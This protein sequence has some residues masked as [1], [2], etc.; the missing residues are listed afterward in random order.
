[1]TTP[2]PNSEVILRIMGFTEVQAKDNRNQVRAEQDPVIVCRRLA[3]FR[4]RSGWPDDL[5]VFFS[6]KK[7]PRRGEAHLDFPANFILDEACTL[8]IF[9]R[10]TELE[11]QELRDRVLGDAPLHQFTLADK[12]LIG[13]VPLF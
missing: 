4:R 8:A 5:G 9:A 11:K 7:A 12:D 2:R 13:V 1:V 6:Y 10:M 3:A